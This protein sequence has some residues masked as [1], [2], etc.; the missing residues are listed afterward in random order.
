MQMV[1]EFKC[2]W[3]HHILLYVI[4]DIFILICSL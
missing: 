4:E 2:E 1:Y 3:L